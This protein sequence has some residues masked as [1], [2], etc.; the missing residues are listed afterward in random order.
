[1]SFARSVVVE[2]FFI[3]L[4]IIGS[5]LL[6]LATQAGIVG[7][8][9]TGLAILLAA[10]LNVGL[11]LYWYSLEPGVA[12]FAS[13]KSRL[14]AINDQITATTGGIKAADRAK[15]NH[16]KKHTVDQAK[17]AKEQ[18]AVE[19]RE[20]KEVTARQ[21]ALQ[22]VLSSINTRRQTINQ[23][24]A[25]ALRKIQRDVGARVATLIQEIG[26]LAQAEATELTAMLKAQQGQHIVGYLR[27]FTLDATSISGVGPSYKSRLKSAGFQ[28]AAD[29]DV[30]RVQ[31]V[32]GIGPSR[33][34]SL[35]AWKKS[36]E[37]RA[38]TSMPQ[39]LSQSDKTRIQTKYQSQRFPL[40]AE[41][42]RAQQRQRDEE[43]A[44]R[45][46]YGRSIEQLDTEE[47]VANT[48]TKG[49]IDEIQAQYARQYDSFR[50]A[51]A[52]LADETALT[53]SEIDGGISEARKSL[54]ALH[55]QKE[56]ERRHLKAFE[57]IRFSKYVK[58]V[59]VGSRAA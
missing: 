16:R 11:W 35:V 1:M 51:L 5:L 25:D 33:A 57:G 12:H 32:K 18:K 59:F 37:S 30:Y 15:T 17:I 4:S 47:S 23:Q 54:F 41:R 49:E 34:A 6:I 26:K 2:R 40:V 10:L 13:L 31:R 20:T 42:D 36:I 19:W 29:I 53:L 55:W 24:E 22:S 45:A 48:K 38:Q 27:G 14:R 46:R 9:S 21:M 8:G 44:I 58:R 56:K 3:G 39:A 28:T 7:T 52:K 43:N 50:E